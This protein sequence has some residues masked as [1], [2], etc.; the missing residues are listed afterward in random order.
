MEDLFLFLLG[1]GVIWFFR[2]TEE[3]SNCQHGVNGGP[4]KTDCEKFTTKGDH[5]KLTY[6]ALAFRQ[7]EWRRLTFKTSALKFVTVAKLLNRLY[8]EKFQ[9]KL[10]H[11]VCFKEH[12]NRRSAFRK[13]HKQLWTIHKLIPF[14]QRTVGYRTI[15]PREKQSSWLSVGRDNCDFFAEMPNGIRKQ[16]RLQSFHDCLVH[17]IYSLF[18]VNYHRY[19]SDSKWIVS[20]MG[21]LSITR[22]F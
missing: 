16:G 13:Y 2:R 5:N 18:L 22:S 14:E 10:R 1:G 15:W 21:Q 17:T 20:L 9:I 3:D 11:H 6:R 12:F 19:C 8:G 4:W 7:S